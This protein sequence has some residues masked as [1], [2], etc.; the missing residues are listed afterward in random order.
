[1]DREHLERKYAL[2][3]E[4]WKQDVLAMADWYEERIATL[5]ERTRWKDPVANPPRESGK[6]LIK[7]QGN[8]DL[9]CVDTAWYHAEPGKA[10]QPWEPS[11]RRVVGWCELPEDA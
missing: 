8:E 7:F 10:F 11:F 1:M 6:Y 2:R 4:V 3:T 5:S 9:V